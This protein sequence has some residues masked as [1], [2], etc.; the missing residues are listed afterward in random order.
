MRRGR[1]IWRYPSAAPWLCRSTDSPRRARVRAH[2]VDQALIGCL[3]QR[4]SPGFVAR[5]TVQN[6]SGNATA[7]WQ[8]DWT[9]PHGQALTAIW[10]AAATSTGG[11]VSAANTD[12]NGSLAAGA[13]TTFGFLGTGAA[14]TDLTLA[15]SPT[16]LAEQ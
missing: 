4:S 11:T 6:T 13:S 1:P 14:P 10:S 8:V 5:V 16:A 12:Y 15:C 2:R 7:G 9:W 3:V